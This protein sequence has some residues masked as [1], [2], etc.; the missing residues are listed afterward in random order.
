MLLPRS[1]TV[2]KKSNG[3]IGHPCRTPLPISKNDDKKPLFVTQLNL[4]FNK[5]AIHLTKTSPKPYA[6]RAFLIA[7]I[8][9]VSKAYA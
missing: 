9:R 2:R 8:E 3:E 4:S 1:S 6:L 7:E 5:I